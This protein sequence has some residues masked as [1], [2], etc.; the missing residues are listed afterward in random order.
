MTNY[1]TQM[2]KDAININSETIAADSTLYN[3]DR[4]YLQFQN[5]LFVQSYIFAILSLNILSDVA[6]FD[7]TNCSFLIVYRGAV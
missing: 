1:Y 5:I 2:F 7:A 4:H 3:Y 6:R